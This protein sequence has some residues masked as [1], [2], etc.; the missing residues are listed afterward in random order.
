[1]RFRVE[2]RFLTTISE[3]CQRRAGHW[4]EP[5]IAH[6]PVWISTSLLLSSALKP[7]TAGA[8]PNSEIKMFPNVPTRRFLKSHLHTL[9][10]LQKS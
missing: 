4:F 7:V 6:H 3:A 2:A 9:M 5:S 10:P 1:M 8:L